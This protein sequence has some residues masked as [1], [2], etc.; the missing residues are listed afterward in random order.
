MKE[1]VNI[2]KLGKWE[3]HE[4]NLADIDL[5]SEYIKA[6]EY[7]ANLWSAN[8]AYLWA[9][10]QSR[11]RSILWR[12]VDGM[13]VTFAHSYKNS[14]YLYCLPFGA[15]DPEHLLDVITQSLQY[16]Y[17]WN[18]QL[19]TR[20][21]IRMINENQLDFLQ[22]SPTFNQRYRLVI[23]QGIERHFDLKKLISLA[24]QDYSN[25]RNRVNK[26]RREN[27]DVVF[28]KYQ[29]GDFNAV[30]ALDRHW[31]SAAGQ[32]YTHI[33][34][35][36]YYTAMIE[37]Y[38]ALHELIYVMECRGKL[39]GMVSGS[40]LPTGQA[41][42]SLLKYQSGIP[43]LSEALTVEFA[44]KLAQR[45]PDIGFFNVGSD[46]GPGGLREYKLKFRPALNLKRYQ[47]YPV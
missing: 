4:I 33:F 22:R 40:R 42:G 15:A 10:S 7:P 38:Q 21:L 35:N 46:L 43:G 28:R 27:P 24:G 23:L 16:C 18:Q 25:V 29:S 39:I 20:T 5:Y 14:L 2:R 37:N 44:R 32:K 8:F 1:T 13:L 12:F 41:W 30:I 45:H 47:V 9:A 11:L 17:D 19:K 6:T 3:F 31:K 34:D 26:F 36:V